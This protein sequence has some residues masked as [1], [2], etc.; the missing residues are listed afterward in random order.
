MT[1]RDPKTQSEEV[2]DLLEMSSSY[3]RFFDYLVASGLEEKLA[4]YSV[5]K[6]FSDIQGQMVEEALSLTGGEVDFEKMKQEDIP[7]KLDEIFEKYKGLN[8]K[9]YSDFLAEQKVREFEAL[10]DK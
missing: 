5:G 6:L 8:M 4:M 2:F 1:K 9:E 3:R 10:G 7:P